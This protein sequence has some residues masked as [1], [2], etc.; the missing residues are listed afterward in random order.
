MVLKL[1]VATNSD[2]SGNVS[3]I[4]YNIIV[5]MRSFGRSAG[6]QSTSTDANRTVV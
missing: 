4:T 3:R 6:F 1:W 5:S 2:E